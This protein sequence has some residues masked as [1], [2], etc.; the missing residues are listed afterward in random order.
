[1]RAQFLVRRQIWSWGEGGC[2]VGPAPQSPHTALTLA[3]ERRLK[4]LLDHCCLVLLDHGKTQHKPNPAS[5]LLGTSGAAMLIKTHPLRALFG[6]NRQL[7]SSPKA[8]THAAAVLM[9]PMRNANGWG[10]LPTAMSASRFCNLSPCIAS[11][12]ARRRRF[13]T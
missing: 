5:P 2:G 6:S 4:R 13:C 1:M 7:N 11:P 12:R 10:P 3:L 9:W 8:Q